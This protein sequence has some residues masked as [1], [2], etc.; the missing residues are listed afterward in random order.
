MQQRL[1]EGGTDGA[2][3]RSSV[4]EA[5]IEEVGGL[6]PALEGVG[7]KSQDGGGEA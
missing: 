5:S 1:G 7:A 3:K 4:K 6:T 2:D